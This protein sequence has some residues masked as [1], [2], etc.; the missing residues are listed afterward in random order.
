VG[1]QRKRRCLISWILPPAL[2]LAMWRSFCS[3]SSQTG[4]QLGTPK[5]GGETDGFYL[6][7]GGFGEAGGRPMTWPVVLDQRLH[8]EGSAHRSD[9]FGCEYGK[10]VLLGSQP[11]LAPLAVWIRRPT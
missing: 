3:W 10:L 9:G 7:N 5:D 6:G 1:S 11:W 8:S 2:S 4:S